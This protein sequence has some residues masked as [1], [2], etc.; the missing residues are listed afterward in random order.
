MFGVVSVQATPVW[1]SLIPLVEIFADLS[2]G[3][4]AVC[5]YIPKMLLPRLLMASGLSKSSVSV[6]L[7]RLDALGTSD[8]NA[9]RDAA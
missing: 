5:R 2:E 4:P 7:S 6:T 9:G 1:R 3:D 8:S